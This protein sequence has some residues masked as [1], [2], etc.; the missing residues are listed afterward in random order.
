MLQPIGESAQEW[1]DLNDPTCR[2]VMEIY[3]YEFNKYVL[4]KSFHG[5]HYNAQFLRED[6]EIDQEF[7]DYFY[8]PAKMSIEKMIEEDS[9]ISAG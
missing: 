8:F 3:N 5:I 4:Y 1:I 2:L 6:K 9:R 7:Y